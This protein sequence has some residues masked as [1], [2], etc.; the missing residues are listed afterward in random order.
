MQ[1]GKILKI[2]RACTTIWYPRV[3]VYQQLSFF[4]IFSFFKVSEVHLI[5]TKN[6]YAP[7]D[8]RFAIVTV[9]GVEAWPTEAAGQSVQC[10]AK[11]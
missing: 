8:G 9:S 1:V 5:K 10:S 7:E 3:L 6:Q 4:S 11:E 2:K